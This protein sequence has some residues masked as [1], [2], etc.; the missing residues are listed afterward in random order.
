MTAGIF[1]QWLVEFSRDMIKGNR[2]VTPVV[3]NCAA[4]PNDSADG[5]SHIALFFLPSNVTSLIQPCDMRI[6]RNLK[7]MYRKRI[8]ARIIS[9]IDTGIHMPVSQLAKS[10]SL[11]N[12]MHMLKGPG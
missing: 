11:L 2:N 5:L 6:V 8:V 12:A 9:V 7:A 3:D 1:R 4:H 10:I